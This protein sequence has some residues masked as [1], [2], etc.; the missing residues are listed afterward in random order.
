M[1]VDRF[2]HS[3]VGRTTR[4]FHV[5]SS[6]SASVLT[7]SE[8]TEGHV[9]GEAAARGGREAHSSELCDREHLLSCCIRLLY[10]NYFNLSVI[11]RTFLMRPIT[12]EKLLLCLVW[13]QGLNPELHTR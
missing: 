4:V 10:P 5:V 3:F 2:L 12:Q 7:N 8:T 1:P 6:S 13:N 11:M 9:K